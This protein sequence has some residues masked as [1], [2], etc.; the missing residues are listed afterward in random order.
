MSKRNKNFEEVNTLN[1]YK[2]MLV[3]SIIEKIK[4]D[5]IKISKLNSQQ[6][7]ALVTREWEALKDR[8]KKKQDGIKL[9]EEQERK[10]I[11][12][13]VCQLRKIKNKKKKSRVKDPALYF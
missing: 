1:I 13:F 9:S 3:G 10:I 8:K 2:V 7:R 4:V 6:I 5:E 11:N 12:W